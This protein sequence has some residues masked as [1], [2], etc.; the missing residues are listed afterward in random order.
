MSACPIELGVVVCASP[1]GQQPQC[2]GLPWACAV[3][4][5]PEAQI[6]RYGSAHVN[7]MNEQECWRLTLSSTSPGASSSVDPNRTYS[8]SSTAPTNSAKQYII[9]LILKHTLREE[10]EAMASGGQQ[11]QERK[12]HL[13]VNS[14]MDGAD[15][16]PKISKSETSSNIRG[17]SACASMW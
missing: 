4:A 7:C 17:V 9:S 14:T 3:L 16:H 11:N 12:R 8:P 6:H 13:N 2:Q 5:R 1:A 15:A 10:K